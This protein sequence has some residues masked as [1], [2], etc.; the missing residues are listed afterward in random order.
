MATQHTCDR[1]KTV[2]QS[3]EMGG[4]Y[5]KQCGKEANHVDEHDRHLCGKCFA[6]WFR[7]RFKFHP[8]MEDWYHYHH[9]PGH[10]DYN[11]FTREKFRYSDDTS[12]KIRV[13]YPKTGR[14][15]FDYND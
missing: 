8:S 7:K 15:G 3:Y 2:S 11:A 14:M 10:S 13:E 5:R 1:M 4:S 6:A 12:A 9:G